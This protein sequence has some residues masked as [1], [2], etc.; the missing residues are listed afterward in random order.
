MKIAEEFIDYLRANELRI[1]TAESCT[2]GMIIA[3]L[4]DIPGSGSLMDCGYVVY[5][6]EAKKRLLQVKQ[7]TI[8]SY[9]L[10]SEEVAREMAS[11]ALYDSTANAAIATTGVAGPDPVDGIAP[12]TVC[13][14]WAFQDKNKKVHSFSET[15]Q[16]AGDRPKFR[17]VAAR[18][19]LTQFAHYHQKA[20][21]TL[22]PKR[23]TA[24]KK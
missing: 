18:Y 4:A 3:L 19:A 10:T 16:F 14:C 20:R 24:S 11:G 5:S 7:S 6:I 23:I 9:N 22:T 8:D 12:G 2:A 21:S 17:T 13:I 1:T 15:K